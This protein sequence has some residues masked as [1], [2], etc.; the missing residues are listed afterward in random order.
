MG[1]PNDSH[2]MI[3]KTD[4]TGLLHTGE[5]LDVNVASWKHEVVGAKVTEDYTGPHNTNVKNDVKRVYKSN[6]NEHVD[7]GKVT[8]TYKAH[9]TTVATLRKAEY[10]TQETHVLTTVDETYDGKHTTTVTAGGRHEEVT[11]SFT[12]IIHGPLD[13][14]VDGKVTETLKGG[15]Q[16]TVTGSATQT[17][18]GDWN[19]EAEKVDTKSR[20]QWKWSCLGDKVTFTVGA[21]SDTILGLKNENVIIAKIDTVVGAHIE[22]RLAAKIEALIGV[23]ISYNSAPGLEFGPAQI[24]GIQAKIDSFAIGKLMRAGVWLSAHGFEIHG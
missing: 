18:T 15:L 13:Q 11:P 6:L 17:A 19:I 23:H 1:A 5:S 10:K 7:T 4:G 22:A 20:G 9:E 8:E 24:K 16:T 3:L 21:T 12:Q 2:N 14:T